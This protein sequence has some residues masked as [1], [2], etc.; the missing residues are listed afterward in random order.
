MPSLQHWRGTKKSGILGTR[1]EGEVEKLENPKS[2][3]QSTIEKESVEFSAEVADMW[4]ASMDDKV[5][6]ST[7]CDDF[8]EKFD[9]DDDNWDHYWNTVDEVAD[10]IL[11]AIVP[12]R[13]KGCDVTAGEQTRK[14]TTWLML[15]RV[16]FRVLEEVY[17]HTCWSYDLC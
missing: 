10:D 4:S 9:I 13:D 2:K 14:K 11:P 15:D 8:D 17:K 1:L 7:T 3:R 16:T 12:E 6:T 5:I